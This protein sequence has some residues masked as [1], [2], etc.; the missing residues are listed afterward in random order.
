MFVVTQLLEMLKPEMLKD[1]VDKILDF[2]EEKIE[3]T[4]TNIDDKLALPLIAMA[5]EAFGIPDDD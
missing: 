5:R 2:F 1:A 4:E 3:E